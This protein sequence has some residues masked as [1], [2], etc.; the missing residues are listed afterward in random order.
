MATTNRDKRNA[1]Y[2]KCI[3][4]SDAPAA[5]NDPFILGLKG[6]KLPDHFFTDKLD[7][8]ARLDLRPD[9]HY[10]S[11]SGYYLRLFCKIEKGN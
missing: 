11:L 7:F 9:P 1:V 10:D 5:L 4:F 3:Y 2:D 8:E 6:V